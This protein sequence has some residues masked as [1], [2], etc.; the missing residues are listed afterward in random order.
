MAKYTWQLEFYLSVC[1]YFVYVLWAVSWFSDAYTH[2][3][4][5]LPHFV[6]V[7]FQ[8]RFDVPQMYKFH[9]KKE[10]DIAVDLWRF[11]PWIKELVIKVDVCQL[12]QAKG[13]SKRWSI[14]AQFMGNLREGTCTFASWENDQRTSLHLVSSCEPIL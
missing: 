8:L 2:V 10:V 9:K 1:T 4:D 6:F 12:K 5:I 14:R 11:V 7:L 3:S 13:H